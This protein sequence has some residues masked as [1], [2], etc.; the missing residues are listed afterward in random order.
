MEMGCAVIS[1][2]LPLLRPYFETFFRIRGTTIFTKTGSSQPSK[3]DFS[4]GASG[5]L[6]HS[7]RSKVDS[8]GFE[9]ISDLTVGARER[10]ASDI[11]LYNR[12]ILVKTDLIIT[13]ESVEDVNEKRKKGS[14]W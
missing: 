5:N 2:N 1:G 12:N 7:A 11:D 10:N 13:T 8:D 4:R 6:S 9:R 14:G 3:S